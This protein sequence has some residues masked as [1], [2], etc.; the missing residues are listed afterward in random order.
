MRETSE[1]LHDLFGLEMSPARVVTSCERVSE[2]LEPVYTELVQTL[3]QQ[4]VVNVDETRWKEQS[5]SA[6]AAVEML[7][8]TSYL[9]P[10]T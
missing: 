10:E 7:Y 6:V 8:A 3:P 4:P 2:A 9:K 1:A 5:R